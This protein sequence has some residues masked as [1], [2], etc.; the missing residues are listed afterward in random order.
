MTIAIYGSRS[1]D[2]N[3]AAIAAFI[4]F[5]RSRGVD[6][7]MHHRLYTTLMEM[8]PEAMEGVERVFD[9]LDFSADVVV[10]FG[11]DGTFLRS[12]MWV[13]DKGIPILGVNTGH[14]GYLTTARVADL[15]DVAEELMQDRYFVE[16]RSLIEVVS[17][18]LRTWPYALN[19]VVVNKYET[20]SMVLCDTQIDGRPLA[21]YRA[22][23]L[24][25]STPTGSTA[26]SLSVGG[27]LI[28]P[29]VPVWVL[30]PIAAHSL[31]LRPLVVSDDQH[32]S[33]TVDSRASGFRLTLDGRTGTFPVGT[34]VELRKASFCVN[35]ICREGYEFPTALRT[36]LCWGV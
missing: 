2:E 18:R 23:G 4:G 29:S 12:A 35:V 36:K 34:T 5:F 20:S 30:S 8:I 22:D 15:A 24:I 6:V 27:P 3:K 7:L 13:G 10:S 25:V 28:Q 31:S 17:P 19:E 14:L 26:Y 9:G 11:G 21:S 33:I 32:I 1:Q 16:R